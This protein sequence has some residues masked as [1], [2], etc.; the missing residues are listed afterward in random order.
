MEERRCPAANLGSAVRVRRL[1]PLSEAE[2]Y[3]RCYGSGFGEAVKVFI[4]EFYA[5]MSVDLSLLRPVFGLSALTSAFTPLQD[6][7]ISFV[8]LQK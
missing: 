2:C 6:L 3:A 4:S 8:R 5:R 1:R 7:F